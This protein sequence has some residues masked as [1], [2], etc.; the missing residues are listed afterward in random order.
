MRGQGPLNGRR[1][2]SLGMSDYFLHP[3]GIATLP[4]RS[5]IR[6]RADLEGEDLPR[7]PTSQASAQP[8]T[9]YIYPDPWGTQVQ[10]SACSTCY[11][12]C[13]PST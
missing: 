6:P 8:R 9:W 4:G 2:F 5:N 10:A 11:S 12:T 13:T 3:R 1:A 7:P